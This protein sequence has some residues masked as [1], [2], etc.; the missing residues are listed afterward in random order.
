MFQ[1]R[2]ANAFYPAERK[3]KRNLWVTFVLSK[4]QNEEQHKN[5]SIKREANKNDMNNNV[6]GH[7]ILAL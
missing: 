4:T 7:I 2:S 3:K 5:K 6:C 1:S